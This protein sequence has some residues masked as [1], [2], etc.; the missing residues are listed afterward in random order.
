MGDVV[1]V[2]RYYIAQRKCLINDFFE[3]SS[4]GRNPLK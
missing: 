2:L 4:H 3:F 1:R